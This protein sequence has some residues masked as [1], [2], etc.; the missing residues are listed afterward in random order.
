MYVV[1][2]ITVFGPMASFELG[3]L[4]WATVEISTPTGQAS[5][6]LPDINPPVSAEIDGTKVCHSMHSAAKAS[7]SLFMIDKPLGR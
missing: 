3:A 4:A 6:V 2:P 1:P 5:K 7:M